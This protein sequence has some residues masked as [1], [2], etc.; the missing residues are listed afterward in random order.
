MKKMINN[1]D[2]VIEELMSGYLIAYPEYIRRS[3]LHKRALI[4]KKRNDKRKVSILIGGG[5][6]H[7]PAFL[8][9][10]GKGMADGVAVGNIFCFTFANTY[11]GSYKRNK[12]WPWRTLY[13]WKLRRRFNEF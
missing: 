5:S 12:S 8:G 13:L 1:P 3:E 10:V 4:G 7:E 6:G 2:N 9:Y 11:T